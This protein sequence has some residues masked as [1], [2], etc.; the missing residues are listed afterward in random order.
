MYC[1]VSFVSITTV[2]YVTGCIVSNHMHEKGLDS[3]WL[4]AVELFFAC[5]QCKKEL[6]K[7]NVL[8]ILA[9]NWPLN[10][11]I[12]SGLIISFALNQASALDG[13]IYDAIFP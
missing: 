10:N 5:R 11:S 8:R 3:D 7:C 13:A 2:N 4:R 6:I 9:F 12:L 1:N